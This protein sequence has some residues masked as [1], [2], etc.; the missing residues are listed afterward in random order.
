MIFDHYIGIDYSGA[1]VPTSSLKGLRIY[2]GGQA[3]ASPRGRSPK[4]PPLVLFAT[5]EWLRL[6]D[7]AGILLDF[8]S[9]VLAPHDRG[10][11]EI[12]GWILG[13][14]PTPPWAILN[15]SPRI[16]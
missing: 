13:I 3:Y 12:E 8:L 14:A 2:E 16:Q 4:K 11:A 9:P 7:E 6:S 1:E 5:A 10:I 15:A